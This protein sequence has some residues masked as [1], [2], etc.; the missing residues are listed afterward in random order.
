M[1]HPL[2]KRLYAPNK[3]V[4]P[5]STETERECRI[6]K[7]ML[8]K[9]GGVGLAAPQ[10]GLNKQIIIVRHHDMIK[11]V[12]EDHVWLNPRLVDIPEDDNEL[13]WGPEGCLSH[14]GVWLEI[15]RPKRII[16]EVQHPNS[17]KRSVIELA[18]MT[19]RIFM[20][21]YD[22]LRGILITDKGQY[23]RNM[24]IDLQGQEKLIEAEQQA[25]EHGTPEPEV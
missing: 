24:N 4:N 12:A 7:V 2:D 9:S 19:A 21:E 25:Q 10:I 18:G 15:A 14:P 6:M 22:H 17:K 16:V 3:E 11:G 5:L 23:G 1:T 13:V 20:H 8:K